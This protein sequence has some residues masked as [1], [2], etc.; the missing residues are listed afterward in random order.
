MSNTIPDADVGQVALPVSATLTNGVVDA[1]Y[2]LQN[3]EALYQGRLREQLHLGANELGAIQYIRRMAALGHDARALDV[4]RSLGVSDGATSVIVSR[5]VT[6]GYLTR[7]ANPRDGRGKLL[8]LTAEATRIFGH[9]LDDDTSDLSLLVS[10]L[11]QRDARRI[12][13]FLTAMTTSLDSS[14]DPHP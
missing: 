4:T 10:T 9:N 7:T 1:L 13:G 6:R 2:V 5:L 8:Y 11:S 14:G 12:V 3:A